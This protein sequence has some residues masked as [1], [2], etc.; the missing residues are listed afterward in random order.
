MLLSTGQYTSY[1]ITQVTTVCL[2]GRLNL[3]TAS[4]D[5][6]VALWPL[7]QKMEG[8]GRGITE[9]FFS[10][11][12]VRGRICVSSTLTWMARFKIHQNC[13]KCLFAVQLSDA[14]V[15][16]ATAGDDGAVAFSRMSFVKKATEQISSQPVAG[17]LADQEGTLRASSATTTTLLLPKAHAS[18]VTA[19]QLLDS[20]TKS[21]RPNSPQQYHF[22]TSST[23]QRLKTWRLTIDIEKPGVEGFAVSKVGNEATGV[24]DVSSMDVVRDEEVGMRGVVVAG[25]GVE[26]WAMD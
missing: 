14:E 20:N 16:L 3:C 25:I 7:N 19:L 6:Y 5:G 10:C 22:I 17:S 23:D 12:T 8:H 24:A 15:L 18:A 21:K 26:V 2:G 11:E 4:T 13:I 1:C 9:E